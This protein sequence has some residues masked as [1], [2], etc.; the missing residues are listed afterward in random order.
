MQDKK[1]RIIYNIIYLDSLSNYNYNYKN[2]LYNLKEI[3]ITLKENLKL[4]IYNF[5]SENIEKTQN[6]TFEDE[7]VKRK[8]HNEK[9][10]KIN[11]NERNES[12][13]IENILT[14]YDSESSC[15]LLHEKKEM[16]K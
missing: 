13:N 11:I 2:K 7:N 16:E 4:E 15:S 12:L 5:N 8:K 9:L 14:F 1:Q 6:K 3:L 10:I